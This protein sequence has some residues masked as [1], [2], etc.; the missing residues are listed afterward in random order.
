MG[1][2]PTIL[3]ESHSAQ[4]RHAANL[5]RSGLQVARRRLLRWVDLRRYGVAVGVALS[6]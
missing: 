2:A 1:G 3:T 6:F 5:K 4:V